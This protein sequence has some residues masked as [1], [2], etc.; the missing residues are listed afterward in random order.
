MTRWWCAIAR[1]KSSGRPG[2]AGYRLSFTDGQRL[3]CALTVLADGGRSSLREQLGIRL[4]AGLTD[5]P[6]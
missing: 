3:E 5:E 1:P 2:T 4:R 6:R